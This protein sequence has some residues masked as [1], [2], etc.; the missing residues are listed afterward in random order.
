MQT[1]SLLLSI[2]ASFAYAS[3]ENSDSLSANDSIKILIAQKDKRKTGYVNYG[4]KD[5]WWHDA[6]SQGFREAMMNNGYEYEW[7]ISPQYERA[8]K[9][10]E[11][12][13]AA[14]VLNGKTGYIDELNRY[15]LLPRFEA[16]KV[17]IA[18]SLGKFGL[19]HGNQWI[20]APA[21]DTVSTLYHGYFLIT[22]MG[23]QA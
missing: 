7:T 11:E 17:S 18:D 16:Q 15:I 10:F 6:H 19:K 22:F 23:K 8:A 21:L 5:F 1:L 3:P 4:K 12:G 20:H 14:V 2:L 9:R 13:L